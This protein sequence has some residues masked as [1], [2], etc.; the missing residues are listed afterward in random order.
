MGVLMISPQAAFIDSDQTHNNILMDS[1][2]TVSG[3]SNPK[4]HLHKGFSFLIF[5]RI[6]RYYLCNIVVGLIHFL[7]R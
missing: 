7:C 2:S 1:Q 6:I 5:L 3:V 4:F